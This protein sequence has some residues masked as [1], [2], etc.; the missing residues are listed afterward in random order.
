MKPEEVS[1]F[2]YLKITNP[3]ADDVVFDHVN[4]DIYL[5]ENKTTAIKHK[6]FLRIKQKN[7]LLKRLPWN[8]RLQHF[9]I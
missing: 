8:C 9:L 3:T 6:K 7:L 4:A 1:F 5:D 2:I